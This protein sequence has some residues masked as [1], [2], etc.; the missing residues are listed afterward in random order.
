MVMGAVVIEQVLGVVTKFVHTNCLI[1][2]VQARVN[3]EYY[4]TASGNDR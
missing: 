1:S 4:Y 3:S 2:K